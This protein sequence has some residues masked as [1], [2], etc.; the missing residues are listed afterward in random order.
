MD[1]MQQY[2]GLVVNLIS[3]GNNNSNYNNKQNIKIS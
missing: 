1:I 3:D 2:L